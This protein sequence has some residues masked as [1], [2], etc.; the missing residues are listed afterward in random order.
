MRDW[1]TDIWDTGVA[2]DCWKS[3]L[4]NMEL[5]VSSIR[6]IGAWSLEESVLRRWLCEGLQDEI[7]MGEMR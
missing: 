3:N 6:G 4:G 5:E 1:L 7:A 2:A